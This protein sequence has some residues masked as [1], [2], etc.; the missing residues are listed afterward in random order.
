MKREAVWWFVVALA[1]ISGALSRCGDRHRIEALELR[2]D[3]LEG[4]AA[5]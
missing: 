2:V 5:K 3:E 4:K 1:L